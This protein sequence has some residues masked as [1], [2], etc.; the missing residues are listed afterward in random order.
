VHHYILHCIGY[1]R[2]CLQSAAV[3]RYNTFVIFA[4]ERNTLVEVRPFFDCFYF[5]GDSD[6]QNGQYEKTLCAA[7]VMEQP[8]NEPICLCENR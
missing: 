4:N 8:A 5:A 7:S 2:Y 6:A 3:L 1:N